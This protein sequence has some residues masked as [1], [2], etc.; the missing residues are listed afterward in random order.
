MDGLRTVHRGVHRRAGAAGIAIGVLAGILT[1]ILAG[2]ALAQKLA[3][4]GAAP[5]LEATHVPPLLVAAGERVELRYDVFCA[6]ADDVESLCDATGTAFVRPGTSGPFSPVAV[7]EDRAADGRFAAVV[8]DAIAQSPAGFTY[9]ATFRTEAG[10]ISVP[11]GGAASPQRSLPLGKPVR[12]VLGVHTFGQTAHATSRVADAAWGS[13]PG[14]VGLEQ[15]R[16]LTPIGG[17][18]FD[19]SA[20]GTVHLL[21]EANRRVLRWRPGARSATA[22]VPVAINGTLADMSVARDG[23]MHVLETTNGG[24]DTQ[25][26]RT[27]T[28]AGESKGAATVAGRASQIRLRADDVP[29]VLTQP[30]ARWTPATTPA[31]DGLTAAAQRRAG[32]VA[33]PLSNGSEVVVLRRGAEIRVAVTGVGGA[34]RSWRI[35][36]RTPL[37]EVQLA[38]TSGDRLV[39]VA[40]VYTDAQDEFVALVLGGGAASSGSSRST[41]P[42]GPRPRPSRD[43][44]CAARPSTNWA[45]RQQVSS[46]TASIWR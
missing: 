32:T 25:V 8:P 7:R 41:P 5:V 22:S 37:A 45:R 6:A 38:E 36:S 31:G 46:S 23:T 19:V 43:S 29:V 18:S 9:F 21:D 35:T 11:E 28:A 26:L 27:V 17:A 15:G 13:G 16:N 4:A 44:A 2:A 14:Q 39:V 1:V 33:R 10:T 42:T 34:R 20:D 12:V 30:S 24:R 3:P 40:R